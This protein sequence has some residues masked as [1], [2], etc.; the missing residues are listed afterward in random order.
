MKNEKINMKKAESK[1]GISAA[2]S[3]VVIV[4]V[5][6]VVGF[7]ARKSS[8]DFEKTVV[9]QTQQHL[10]NIAKTGA[11]D[12]QANVLDW[13]DELKMLAENPRIKRAVINDE[14]A[15]D[16]LEAD[17]YSPEIEVYKHLEGFI[18]GL[19]KL[20]AKGIVQS[21]IP[22]AE[23]REGADFSHK[24][25][26]EVVLK[27]H[28]PYISEFF[29]AASGEK[30]FSVCYPVFEQEQFNG[31]VRVMVYLRSINNIISHIKVGRKGHAWMIDD[32]G[33]MMSHPKPAHVCK[34]IIATRKVAFPD[35]D[36]FE[37]ENI[38]EKMTSGEAGVGSYHSAWWLDEKPQI[39]RKLTAFAPVRIGN[40]LWSI[41]VSM[42]YDEISGPIRTHSRSIFL[43][44]GFII[45]LFIGTGA[46]F[47]RVQKRQL[48][49][50]TQLKSAEQLKSINQKLISEIAERK[51][52]EQRLKQA[53]EEWKSTFD[54]ISD[55]V[56]IQDKDFKFVRVNKAFADAFEMKPEEAIGKSCYGLVHGAKEPWPTCPHK[57]ALDTKKP[58]RAE[59][60]EPHLGLYLEVSVS[61]I[62]D[63]NGEMVGS[64]H[65]AKDIT[66]R[67]S[68]EEKQDELLEKVDNI[69]KELKEFASIVSH[70]LKA[71]LRGIKT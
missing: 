57:D 18:D 10:L 4:V 40:R 55:L 3:L 17:G 9:T 64:V 8:K 62:F 65:I 45:L 59:F 28:K 51:L 60:F 53:N 58:Q 34:D 38:V 33:L 69:N 12:V 37:L 39:T 1:S 26:V 32:S 47:Y 31:I 7:L 71:P 5:I 22:F 66:K 63:E 27:T 43:G 20:D 23:G 41:G 11:Q 13:Q 56:S 15:Q 25:G 16:I 52:A 70:D 50:Q 21:R 14:S 30:C 29:P 54:S 49:L 36:W 68:A 67:K 2:V 35:Y 46:G 61:P 42:D 48:E 19:Y 24:P 6:V 44:A